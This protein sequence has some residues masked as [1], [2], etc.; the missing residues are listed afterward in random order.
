MKENA[1]AELI[2]MMPSYGPPVPMLTFANMMGGLLSPSA[3]PP[4]LD[5]STFVES[6]APGSVAFVVVSLAAGATTQTDP[7][8][9]D[10]WKG[11]ISGSART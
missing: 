9:S 5:T 1:A 6:G 4:A 11:I 7:T 8:F 10:D 3:L 2:V